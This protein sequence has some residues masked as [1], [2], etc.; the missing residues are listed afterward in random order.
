MKIDCLPAPGHGAAQLFDPKEL[1]FRLSAEPKTLL[2]LLGVAPSG[3]L[4]RQ[5]LEDFVLN[6]C[7]RSW[8]RVKFGVSE[9]FFLSQ[10]KG[11][12]KTSYDPV[13]RWKLSVE[14]RSIAEL[15][16]C[17]LEGKEYRLQQYLKSALPDEELRA[18]YEKMQEKTIQLFLRV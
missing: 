3:T 16:F 14:K 18:F 12:D 11:L 5:L 10:I 7:L 8:A 1:F 6:H 17:D 2:W 13:M 9:T 15:M 4:A